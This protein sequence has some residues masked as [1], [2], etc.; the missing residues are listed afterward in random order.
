MAER[1]DGRRL[2]QLRRRGEDLRDAGRACDGA[3]ARRLAVLCRRLYR[4]DRPADV[5]RAE[6][7]GVVQGRARRFAERISARDVG[8]DGAVVGVYVPAKFNAQMAARDA[9]S[10][11]ESRRRW[12]LAGRW[13]WERTRG[14]RDRGRISQGRSFRLR[15]AWRF[16]GAGA[17][18]REG[19]GAERP[20]QV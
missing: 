19:G 7:D 12:I 17:G 14:D 15:R 11:R 8:G 13:L 1:D 4:N 3:G 2:R 5:D 18:E 6:G 10:C 20:N 9:A 16:A